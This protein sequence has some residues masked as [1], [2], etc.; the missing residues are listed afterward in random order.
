[1]NNL[2][3][4]P[5]D[6]LE[7]L[8]DIAVPIALSGV[9]IG[10]RKR[11][12]VLFERM[13]EHCREGRTGFLLRRRGVP[14]RYELEFRPFSTGE[15]PTRPSVASKMHK[16]NSEQRK[17]EA[18]VQTG[19][20]IA[21]L[22]DIE[23]MK[24]LVVLI[25]ENKNIFHQYNNIGATVRP[26]IEEDELPW[27]PMEDAILPGMETEEWLKSW[28]CERDFTG[29]KPSVRVLSKNVIEEKKDNMVRTIVIHDDS[30]VEVTSV[31]RFEKLR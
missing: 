15:H 17:Y 26:L 16:V 28:L 7:E 11:I 8:N 12:K 31:E 6:I 21:P 29:Y 23:K 25:A 5:P 20:K 18:L 2:G 19:V 24:A 30:S 4:L 10:R 1:M 22:S 3:D 14:V 13:I 9:L 27:N